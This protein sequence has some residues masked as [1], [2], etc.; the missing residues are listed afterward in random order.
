MARSGGR[1]QWERQQAALRREIER[2]QREQARLAKEQEKVRQQQHI[3]AQQRTAEAK[4]AAVEQQVKILDE[5]LTGILSLPVLTFDALKVTPVLPRFDP[6]PVAVAASAPDWKDY[7][8]PEPGAL[9]RLLGGAAKHEREMAEA[10]ARF[11]AD[12]GAYRRQ[13]SIR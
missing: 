5:I 7:A 1:S 11:Q 4:T 10:Q 6:G 8:V 12:T 3:E 2:Q 9:S 13:V